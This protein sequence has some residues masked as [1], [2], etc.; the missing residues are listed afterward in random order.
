MR[1]ARERAV[2]AASQG[3]QRAAAERA[4]VHQ[5]D[6]A[7]RQRRKRRTLRKMQV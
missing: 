5:C 6:S 3:R 4:A 1:A 7:A 2:E